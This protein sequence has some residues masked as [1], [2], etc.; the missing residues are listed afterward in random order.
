MPAGRCLADFSMIDRS[1]SHLIAQERRNRG[2]S[3]NESGVPSGV[4]AGDRTTRPL[5]VRAEGRGDATD[6]PRVDTSIRP[7]ARIPRARPK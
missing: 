4:H 5:R 6:V 1:E 3:D 7:A 2:G